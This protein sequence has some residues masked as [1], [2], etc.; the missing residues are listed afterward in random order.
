MAS[1]ISTAFNGSHSWRTQAPAISSFEQ[2]ASFGAF[3]LG[4]SDHVDTT[5]LQYIFPHELAQDLSSGLVL[6]PAHFKELFAQFAL[7][8]DAEAC[9]LH[10]F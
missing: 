9:V 2:W 4:Q 5:M 6:C 8:P 7:Y 1:S 3:L 10:A